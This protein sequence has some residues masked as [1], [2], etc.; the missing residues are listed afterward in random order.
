MGRRWHRWQPRVAHAAAALPV[1]RAGAPAASAEFPRAKARFPAERATTEFAQPLRSRSAAHGRLTSR[2]W[3]RPIDSP[4]AYPQA[5]PIEAA[6]ARASPRRGGPRSP[7]ASRRARSRSAVEEPDQ[8]VALAFAQSADRLRRR[9]PAVGEA[10]RRL[11]GADL[12]H[13]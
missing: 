8:L 7:G 1:R 5:P 9:D 10:A 11:S 6:C 3:T 2:F 13:R 4:Q 12:R